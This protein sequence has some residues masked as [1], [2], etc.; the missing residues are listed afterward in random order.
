MEKHKINDNVHHSKEVSLR[1]TLYVGQMVVEDQEKAL[2]VPESALT[3]Y[4]RITGH[5][6]HPI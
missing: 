6:I 3:L 4:Q 2:A 1:W 5:Y